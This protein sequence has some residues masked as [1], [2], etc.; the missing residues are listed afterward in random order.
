MNA[1]CGE[2]GSLERHRLAWLFLT[3]IESIQA[4]VSRRILHIAPEP[5]LRVRFQS[6]S[7]LSYSAG[8][9]HGGSGIERMDITN[10][11]YA[12][13]SFD[14]IFCSHVLAAFSHEEQEE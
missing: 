12:P 2:C 3:R 14:L 11:E 5:C 9:L 4:P 1:Q 8:D 10:I 13:M 6:L 7:H